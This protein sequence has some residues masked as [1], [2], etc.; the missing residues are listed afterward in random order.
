MELLKVNQAAFVMMAMLG[1]Q[2]D[3]VRTSTNACL[4]E[5]KENVETFVRT[6]MADTSVDAPFQVMSSV[7]GIDMSALVCRCPCHE[8]VVTFYPLQ[9]QNNAGISQQTKL[10]KMVEWYVIGLLKRT[11]STAQCAA[12]TASSFRL[13]PTIMR[14]ADL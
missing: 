14:H 7:L 13:E 8:V 2:E 3:L 10:L 5:G 6:A 4:M 9:W 11:V 1:S 12:T